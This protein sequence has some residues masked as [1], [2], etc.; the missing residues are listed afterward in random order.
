MSGAETFKAGISNG[1]SRVYDRIH[2]DE[3]PAIVRIGDFSSRWKVTH[4]KLVNTRVF[5]ST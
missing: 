3:I 4:W 2:M 5:S 1:K